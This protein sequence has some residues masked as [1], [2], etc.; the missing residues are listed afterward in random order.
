MASHPDLTTF[1]ALSFDC[2]GTLIDWD[3]GLITDLQ[4]ILSLLPPSHEWSR[5]PL[6]A[7]ARFNHLSDQLEVSNPT[8]LYSANLSESFTLLAQE[9]GIPLSSLPADAASNIGTGPGRWSAFPDTVAGLQI[10]KKHY[11]LIIL[12]NVSND[13]IARTQAGPLRDVPFDAVYTAQDIGSYKPAHANFRYLFAHAKEDLGVDFE[14]GELLHAAHSLKADHV[15]A[16]EIGL[17]SVWIARGGDKE[18]YEGSGGD[19]KA[20]SEAG[21]V[22]FEWKFDTIGDFAAEVARQFAAKGAR[23]E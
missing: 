20:L 18:G 14:K 12:S 5:I 11:K 3:T 10:L 8:Q 22:S 17:R 1:K 9:A 6:R 4:P 13:N 2:Y 19:L 15:P 23:G 7:V 21:K 16:K